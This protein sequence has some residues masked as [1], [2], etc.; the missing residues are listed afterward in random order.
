MFFGISGI[1]SSRGEDSDVKC[2]GCI[3]G[4]ED[5][6]VFEVESNGWLC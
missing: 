1:G 6:E 3:S 5:R 2:S 4:G